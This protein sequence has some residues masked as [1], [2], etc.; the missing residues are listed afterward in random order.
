MK[1]LKQVS[2]YAMVGGL[3]ALLVLGLT[4][5]EE[6]Q[7]HKETN[8]FSEAAKKQGAFVVIEET[9]PGQYKIAEEYPSSTT[10]VILRE[11]NGKERILS[12]EELDKLIA[13]EAK[14]IEANQSPLVNPEIHS[15]MS[16]GEVILASAAGAIIGSWLGN[17]LFNNPTYQQRRHQTFKNPSAYQRSVKSFQK[18]QTPKKSSNVKSGFF[19]KSAP[20]TKRSFFGFGG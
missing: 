16:L 19:K 6:K 5:C 2:S 10:R 4:G 20:S 17:K 15:G 8:A 13:A 1:L 11:L 12:K 14:K 3:G 18:A 9:A 7:Q